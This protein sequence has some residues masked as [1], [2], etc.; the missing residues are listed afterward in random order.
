MPGQGRPYQLKGKGIVHR[1]NDDTFDDE[2]QNGAA[3]K[4]RHPT[5]QPGPE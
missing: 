2:P 5:R 3:Q 1:R 4:D